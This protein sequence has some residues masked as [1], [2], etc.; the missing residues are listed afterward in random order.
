LLLSRELRAIWAH[1]SSLFHTVMS[2]VG[3]IDR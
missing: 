3:Q 2:F 1:N